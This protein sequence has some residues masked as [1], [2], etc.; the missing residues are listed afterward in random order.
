[1]R[2]SALVWYSEEDGCFLAEAPD[3]PGCKADGPTA[4]A[5]LAALRSSAASWI[6]AARKLGRAI[7]QPE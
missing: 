3:L 2:Y 5:A 4:E 7:P 6:E 1:M